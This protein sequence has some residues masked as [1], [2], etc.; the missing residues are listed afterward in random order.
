VEL[1]GGGSIDVEGVVPGP[2]RRDRSRLGV[3]SW[4]TAGAKPEV[5]AQGSAFHPGWQRIF[6]AS[7]VGDLKKVRN[8]QKLMLRSRADALV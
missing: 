4:V 8:L 2:V 5:E 1:A 3:A 6:A 7:Q